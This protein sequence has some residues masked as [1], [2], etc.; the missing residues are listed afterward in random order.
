[1]IKLT[2]F[3]LTVL[4]TFL[5]VVTQVLL[6]IWLGKYTIQVLPLK[7]LNVNNI[8]RLEFICAG[9]S[10]LIGGILWMGLLKRVEFSVLYPLISISYIFGL[11]A[12]KFIFHESI[13]GVRWFGVLIIIFGVYLIS[14]N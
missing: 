2:D 10:F 5:L 4:T 11:L 7:D 3:I 6:K 13:P 9:L 1:M 12:A 8:F 14:R